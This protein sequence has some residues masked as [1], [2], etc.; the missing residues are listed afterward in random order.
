[1]PKPRVEIEYCSKCRFILRASWMMQEI[2][3]TFGEE[4][5]EFVLIPGSGGVFV[6]RLNGEI[7]F[8]RSENDRFPESKEIKQMIRDR[9]LPGKSLGH[10]DR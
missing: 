5:G 9:I 2:L 1:M 8:A 10:S 7:L 4:I 6:I 3:M